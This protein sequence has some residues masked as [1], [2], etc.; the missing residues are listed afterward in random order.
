MREV[1]QLAQQLSRCGRGRLCISGCFDSAITDMSEA[2]T[3]GNLQVR[4]CGLCNGL[5]RKAGRRLPRLCLRESSSDVGEDFAG[6]MPAEKQTSGSPH[7]HQKGMFGLSRF[8]RM[9]R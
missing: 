2:K 3:R 4:F 7:C 8:L 1:R 6:S 5:F 9:G